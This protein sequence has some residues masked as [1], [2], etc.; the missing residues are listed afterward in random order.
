MSKSTAI[1][2]AAVIVSANVFQ[3]GCAGTQ[4]FTPNDFCSTPIGINMARIV[5]SRRSG[6]AAGSAVRFRITDDDQPMGD[7]GPG[8]QLC[9]DRY[10]GIA[11]I[12]G[13]IAFAGKLSRERRTDGNR[14]KRSIIEIETRVGYTYNVR[15][16]AT[17][18][19][20]VVVEQVKD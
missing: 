20:G 12:A 3:L 5:M 4:S 8:G 11:H 2:I 1:M 7:V 10:P 15:A 13:E 9:W 19:D 16:Y 6:F 17:M 14:G 18:F